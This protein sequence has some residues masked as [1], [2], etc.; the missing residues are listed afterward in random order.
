VQ[1]E[2]KPFGAVDKSFAAAEGEGDR[3][4]AYW[5]EAHRRYFSPYCTAIG[6]SFDE[7]TPLVCKRFKLVYKAQ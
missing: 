6:R 7:S 2:I 5:R 3:S 1:G 4:L